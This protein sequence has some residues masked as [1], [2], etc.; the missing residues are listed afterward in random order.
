[1][2]AAQGKSCE[3]IKAA[4]TRFGTHTLVGE[5]LLKLQHP[6]MQ[7][8]VDSRYQKEGYKD[9]PDNVEVSNCETISREHK[10]GTAKK[11]VLDED[12]G[13]FWKSV[14]QHVE[15]TKPVIDLLRRHDSSAPTVG[16]AYHGW[17][18]IGEHLSESKH[19]DKDQMVEDH[20]RR[21]AYGHSDFLSAA[22]ALDP[23]FIS[24]DH[25]G[26]EEVMEGL[27]DVIERL[28][29]LFVVRQ[30]HADYEEH[31]KVRAATV[32]KDAKNNDLKEADAKDKK[33]LR[34]NYPELKTE[35]AAKAFCM[36]VNQQ[37]GYYKSKK[38]IFA[39][40]YI[41]DGAETTPAYLWWDSN[42]GSVPELQAVARLVLA[43]PASAS[44]I[45]RINSEFAFVK[46]RR[47]N[48]LSHQKAN[49]LVS[50]FHNLRL[51]RRQRSPTYTEPAVEWTSIES[52]G[53]G[54]PRYGVAHYGEPELLKPPVP[55][56][57]SAAGPS[58]SVITPS[59]AP[60]PPSAMR[61]ITAARP[62]RIAEALASAAPE[63]GDA[64]ATELDC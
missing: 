36:K 64:A 41:I 34:P 33:E 46:D 4:A 43:Q 58:T 5:R 31:W 8:V 32:E 16:K 17:F 26:N 27:N 62:K 42:G 59:T 63:D 49:K 15:A 6:L 30:K 19:P 51:L 3:L 57:P 25:A 55:P 35:S 40:E 38:G 50:L 23:E 52:G 48:R 45:E 2:K 29:I 47:R 18:E 24:H 9:L 44:I 56:M 21:W 11:L 61:P 13:G 60:N 20:T 53:S 7:T 54:I 28:A 10:G 37:Y 12:D 1:M 22:Y 39:R 14:K